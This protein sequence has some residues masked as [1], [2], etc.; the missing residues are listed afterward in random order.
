MERA[1]R[2]EVFEGA[3]VWQGNVFAFELDGH[4]TASRCFVWEVDGQVTAVLEGAGPD[5][6]GR[7]ARVEKGVLGHLN[8]LAP[9]VDALESSVA[10]LGSGSEADDDPTLSITLGSLG[11]RRRLDGQELWGAALQVFVEAGGPVRPAVRVVPGVSLPGFDLWKVVGVQEMP[12]ARR[13]T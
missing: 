4:P 9:I 7:G 1:R 5:G 8:L 6:S 12:L 10:L 3:I 2:R 11:V 13:A